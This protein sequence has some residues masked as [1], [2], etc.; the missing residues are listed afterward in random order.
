MIK[1]ERLVGPSIRR[2]LDFYPV[3]MFLDCKGG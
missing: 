2:A 3:L 1:L